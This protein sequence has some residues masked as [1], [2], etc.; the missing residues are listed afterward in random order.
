MQIF[1]WLRALTIIRG[2]LRASLSGSHLTFAWELES[3]HLFHLAHQV[4]PLW[5]PRCWSSPR[6]FK[7]IA[8]DS[9]SY[10][11]DTTENIN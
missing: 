8:L 9:N 2:G 11:F 5:S 7:R 10:T 6:S 4:Y 3:R 1:F